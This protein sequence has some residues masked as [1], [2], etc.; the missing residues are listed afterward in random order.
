MHNIFKAKRINDKNIKYS[1]A[2]SGHCGILVSILCGN[3]VGSTV[4]Q[5]SS[6]GSCKRMTVYKNGKI[7]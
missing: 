7:K 2:V 1:V 5:K 3:I 4:E 6:K